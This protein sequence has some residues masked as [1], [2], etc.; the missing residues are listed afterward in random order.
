[1][2]D[3]E[4]VFSELLI[5][6]DDL[7]K[8]STGN[9]NYVFDLVTYN[10]KRID[11]Q[12]CFNMELAEFIDSFDWKHWKKGSVD[13][14]NAKMEVVDLLFFALSDFIVRKMNYARV[15]VSNDFFNVLNEKPAEK[16]DETSIIF[17]ANKMFKSVDILTDVVRLA[18]N[19]GMS[20]DDLI[21]LYKGKLVLNTFR[22]KNG[23][24]DGTY[25]K[26]WNVKG[27]YFMKEDN[28][29]LTD[30]MQECPKWDFN[31]LYKK[32]ESLYKLNKEARFV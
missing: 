6:Q 12:L 26:I 13:F 19:I 31:S 21:E 27:R 9:E 3:Y 28:Y 16:I 14:E 11:Y 4:K 24:V 32:L 23:Y 30:L 8:L 22:M 20:T 5:K 25:K 18:H 17:F 2:N 7:N 1:M 10:G 15:S 29:I